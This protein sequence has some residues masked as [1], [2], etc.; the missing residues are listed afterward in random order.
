MHILFYFENAFDSVDREIIWKILNYYGVPD[1]LVKMTIT[2]YEDNERCVH[3]ENGDM[4]FFKIMCGGM[5]PIPIPVFYCY[6]VHS[7]AVFKL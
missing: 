7:K 2:F 3:P 6:G 4:Y 1:K 5:S